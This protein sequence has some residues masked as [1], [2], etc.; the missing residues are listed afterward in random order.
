MRKH[1][2]PTSK[3][4]LTLHLLTYLIFS[5]KW[6]SLAKSFKNKLAIGEMLMLPLRRLFC[7]EST[8]SLPISSAKEVAC[9]NKGRQ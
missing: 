1:L 9:D 3:K 8:S 4:I 7:S 2:E 5:V 6:S